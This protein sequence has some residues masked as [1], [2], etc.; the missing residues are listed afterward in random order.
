MTRFLVSERDLYLAY[1]IHEAVVLVKE[2]KNNKYGAEAAANP[3]AVAVVGH[4]HSQGIKNHWEKVT[5]EEILDI[6]T[7]PEP[8]R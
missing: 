4:G 5:K 7:V 1:T 6:S 8:S 3:V 2:N